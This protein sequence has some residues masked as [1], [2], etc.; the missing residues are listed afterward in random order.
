[1][2]S[3]QAMADTTRNVWFITFGLR[4]VVLLFLVLYA[5]LYCCGRALCIYCECLRG[6][7][8]GKTH[9]NLTVRWWRNIFPS[10]CVSCCKKL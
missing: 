5:A 10:R 2:Q 3:M 8:L 4:C 1:M 9:K 7:R 6:G